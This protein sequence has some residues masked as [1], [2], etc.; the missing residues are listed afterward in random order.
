MDCD[1]A[2]AVL[3]PAELVV[4]DR[5]PAECGHD[6]LKAYFQH[7][8]LEGEPYV[9]E[10]YQYDNTCSIPTLLHRATGIAVWD[11]V[12]DLRPADSESSRFVVLFHFTG[13]VGF[14]S[15]ADRSKMNV[16]L[17]EH[18]Q[19]EY[20][21]FGQGVYC[22][23][24]A[25]D[26][27]KDKEAILLNKFWPQCGDPEAPPDHEANVLKA[28]GNVCAGPS[29]PLNKLVCDAIL[30]NEAHSGKADYCIPMLVPERFAY[31]IWQR[32]TPDLAGQIELGCNRWNELQWEGRDVY[33]VQLTEE[34]KVNSVMSGMDEKLDVPMKRLAKLS[35]TLGPE[36]Q[37]TASALFNLVRTLT[38][39]GRYESAEPL[40]RR[41]V[42]DCEAAFG[43]NHGIT[44]GSNAHLAFVL[45]AM[46]KYDEA[47]P[48]YRRTI[49]AMENNLGPMHLDTV[50][51]R[52][53]LIEVL[54]QI[55]KYDE[56]V[57]LLGAMG[58]QGE[59]EQLLRKTLVARTITLG[60]MHPDTLNAQS[61]LAALLVTMGR[62]AEAEPLYRK[63]YEAQESTLGLMHPATLASLNNLAGLLTAMGKFAD[64]EPL[65]RKTLEAKKATLG[66][67]HHSTLTSRNNLARLLQLMGRFEEALP[68]YRETLLAAETALGVTHPFTLLSV[69]NLAHLLYQAGEY[70]E[71]ES[72]ERRAVDGFFAALGPDHPHTQG[73]V[74]LLA[75]IC[76]RKDATLGPTPAQT[77][78]AA[79]CVVLDTLSNALKGTYS[80]IR[81][82]TAGR[83][84]KLGGEAT[85]EPTSGRTLV[86]VAA[87]RHR[88]AA[89]VTMVTLCSEHPGVVEQAVE[90]LT[91]SSGHDSRDLRECTADAF[92]ELAPYIAKEPALMRQSSIVL[93]TLANASDDGVRIAAHRALAKLKQMGP[94]EI[95]SPTHSIQIVGF[96]KWPVGMGHNISQQH[97]PSEWDN[98]NI[99]F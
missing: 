83:F 35:T 99:V 62:N 4:F 13:P 14:A 54:Q 17:Y 18:F 63:T 52:F 86:D 1:A 72:L 42:L 55:G 21:H 9:G 36:N 44:M 77:H 89:N 91:F 46:G 53:D 75:K 15:I 96:D 87:V 39:L 70:D 88:I 49:E 82:A 85:P 47:E 58:K 50:K 26:V 37:S 65:H 67:K 56:A 33:V 64:A 32:T 28:V 6:E 45:A 76:R 23:G 48:L 80:N 3:W 95:F 5:R 31:G 66:M 11:G 98:N 97:F 2:G 20:S 69:H 12:V 38:E 90:A 7:D 57:R 61:N 10:R 84:G 92:G 51:S 68:L 27:F 74:V 94:S 43:P 34:G 24:S 29:H 78:G 41:S 30:Q 16:E 81:M 71:A 8:Y 25:P 59:A 93:T 73:S 79:M 19:D 22:T 60:G 40:A